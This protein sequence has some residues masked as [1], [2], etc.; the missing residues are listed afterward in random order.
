MMPPDSRYNTA[1]EPGLKAIE[2]ELDTWEGLTKYWK[3]LRQYTEECDWEG[4]FP[5]SWSDFKEDF[6]VYLYESR[7]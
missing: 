2:D 5:R 6:V 3:D 7:Q 1:S 4:S